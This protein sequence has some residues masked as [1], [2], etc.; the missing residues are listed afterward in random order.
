MKLWLVPHTHW[1]REWYRTHEQFRARLVRLLDGLLD[2][3]ERDPAYKHFTLD[4]QMVIVD[5]YLEVRPGARERIARLVREGRLMVGPWYVLPD[6]WLVSGEALIR[7]LRLG[8][9]RAQALGGGMAVGYVPDQFGHV[10]QLP[11][12]FAG[13]GFEAA[14]LWRGV[15]EDVDQTCFEWEAPDGTRLF[16]VYLLQGYGNAGGLPLDPPQLAE[17]LRGTAAVLKRQSPVPSLLLMNGFDHAE[18]EAGL[19]A[20]L[21]AARVHL[22]DVEVAIGTLPDFVARVRKEAPSRLQRHWG[23]LRSGLRAPLLEG[24]ASARLPQK[25][26]DF[27]N[28]RLLTR[29]AE[30]L[31]AW[32]EAVGGR[33]DPEL[34]G[35]AW[36][37]ALENH[38]HDSI[39]G[40][41]IDAVHEQMEARFARVAELAGAELER[42]TDELGRRVATPSG[43]GVPI[44]VWNPGAPGAAEAVGTLEVDLPERGGRFPALHLRSG[45]GRAIPVHAERL[46]DAAVVA[47]YTLPAPAIAAIAGG[48]PAEFAGLFLRDTVWSREGDRPRLEFQLGA[49]PRPGF[50]LA[51]ARRDVEKR[52]A[53]EGEGEVEFRAR[54]LPAVALRFVDELP[55]CGLRTY[56][57]ARGAASGAGGR[58]GVE[59]L[60]K[61]AAIDNGVW[62]IEADADGRV[63]WLHRPSGT[64]MEDA[65]RVVSEGDRGDEYNFDPV[66][67]ETPVERPER[68]RVRAR[69]SGAEAALELDTRLRVPAGLDEDRS[70]RASRRVSL[71]VRLVLRLAR[72]LDRVALTVET[73]NTARDHRLRVHVRAPF[74]ADGFEVESA[75]EVVDRP[76]APLPDAFGSDRPA[77]LPIGACPQRSFAGLVGASLALTLA[78]RGAAEVEAVPEAEGGTSLAV[79]L[80]RAVGWLSRDDLSLR[81]GH[82]GPAL[83]T[84]GAQVPGR[85][86]TELAWWLHSPGDPRRMARAHTFAY[87]APVFP[88]G[89]TARAP[90]GDGDRL[91]EVDDP[92][93]VVSAIEARTGGGAWIR[94]LNA[95]PKTRRFRVRWNG[96]GDSLAAV[97]LRGLPDPGARLEPGDG[98]S[99]HVSLRGW[100]LIGL[101]PIAHG[102]KGPARAEQEPE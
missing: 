17:R 45:D 70:R 35:L 78:N 101:T 11:Q 38:P 47:S 27:R 79:T 98:A 46:E 7:N 88:I 93:V 56:R 85:H 76:I 99:A 87:P 54:R 55:G 86:R 77:E 9:S 100:G 73:T 50:D 96:P 2:L 82:A 69:R 95:S 21:E 34:L 18:P 53:A 6:E 41:S 36:R 3:L 51:V 94:L 39:C 92:E 22:D 43:S 49:R 74:E 57:L 33:A 20:A 58:P 31:S 89:G 8:V 37:V 13:F 72:D 28:D 84:P 29:Y 66:C 60:G 63:C 25:A 83:A 19:P 67:G 16:T 40:C 30:P 15:G 5:D 10:G 80:L 62:R 12:I 102:S 32:L 14:V 59:R 52:L 97:D 24:C 75:F 91:V 90:L 48:F 1:D 64:R 4:G 81:P 71:P 68:V 61:G 26:S 65:V 23:E 42:V 44:A